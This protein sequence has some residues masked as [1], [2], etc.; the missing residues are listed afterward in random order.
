M[1]G[2]GEQAA[3]RA[4][5]KAASAKAAPDAGKTGGTSKSGPIGN[6][7]FGLRSPKAV[8]D[9]GKKT[10]LTDQAGGLTSFKGQQLKDLV[11][12]N[13]DRRG[14]DQQTQAQ[15][16]RQMVAPPAPPGAVDPGDPS[17]GRQ[18]VTA[19]A[20]DTGAQFGPT[21]TFT[22]GPEAGTTAPSA[23]FSNALDA[24]RNRS[25][26]DRLRDMV[27]PLG[28]GSVAPSPTQPSSYVG[29]DYHYGVNPAAAVGGVAGMAAGIPGIGALMGQGYHALGG[30]DV[31]L[32]GPG[33][34]PLPGAGGAPG[35]P[36]G[37]GEVPHN[38]SGT[39][40]PGAAPLVSATPTATATTGSTP[41]QAPPAA[42]TASGP[43][44]NASGQKSQG[45]GTIISG[46][47]TIAWPWQ[48]L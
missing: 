23:T 44:V 15:L 5:A 33:S 34:T 17:F 9:L 48:T 14:N 10:G 13:P 22:A 20:N 1:A 12:G 6:G 31:V 21:D 46:G 8:S 36:A 40:G 26:M 30:P 25:F 35:A 43:G 11:S 18:N 37:G 41:L 42:A 27:T 28:F 29:G 16:L 3:E 47:N 24:Y 19:T 45:G 32:G 38:A 4:K 7:L 2:P 39:G